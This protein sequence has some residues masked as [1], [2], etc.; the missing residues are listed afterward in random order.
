MIPGKVKK[1][2]KGWTDE[3]LA[4]IDYLESFHYFFKFDV[5]YSFLKI[6]LSRTSNVYIFPYKI[7]K[8]KIK[9]ISEEKQ[10]RKTYKL[11]LHFSKYKQNIS[12]SKK[13]FHC[14]KYKKRSAKWGRIHCSGITTQLPITNDSTF[15]PNAYKRKNRA[16]K[17]EKKSSY[18][19]NLTNM[20]VCLKIK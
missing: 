17:K 3:K 9:T 14:S 2:Q 1:R 18:R 12:R 11:T 6:V 4:Q 15:F 13:G 8:V 16:I 19:L 20:A 7:K 5:R 10:L